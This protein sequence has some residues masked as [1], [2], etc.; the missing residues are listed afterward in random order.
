MRLREET[1][2]PAGDPDDLYPSN[3]VFS[4]ESAVN[5]PKMSSP[6]KGPYIAGQWAYHTKISPPPRVEARPRPPI[7]LA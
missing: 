2:L 4:D 1:N 3:L 5:D 6:L 7:A